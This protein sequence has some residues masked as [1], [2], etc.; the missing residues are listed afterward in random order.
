MFF[1]MNRFIFSHPT[2]RSTQSTHVS[3]PSSTRPHLNP[4]LFSSTS[5]EEPLTM[6]SMISTTTGY[7]P[8]SSQSLDHQAQRIPWSSSH[9]DGSNER[10][11][12]IAGS[13][14]THWNPP[15]SRSSS[16]HNQDPQADSNPLHSTTTEINHEDELNSKIDKRLAE[17]STLA[18]NDHVTGNEGS[19]ACTN[20]NGNGES[21]DRNSDQWKQNRKNNHKEV[22]RR[23]RET[24]NE[25]ITEL[26]KIIP[27]TEKNKGE[28]LKQAVKYIQELKETEERNQDRWRLEKIRLEE[29]IQ[30]QSNKFETL[31]RDYLN[32]EAE[33]ESLKRWIIELGEKKTQ[34]MP[35]RRV[36]EEQEEEEEE[37]HDHQRVPSRTS[38]EPTR[39]DPQRN[40]TSNK[41]IPAIYIHNPQHQETESNIHHLLRT[42]TEEF[43]MKRSTDND[44]NDQPNSSKKFKL[45]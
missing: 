29:S 13:S 26:K 34:S 20:G 19:D 16:P 32:L 1:W 30:E 43:G 24:I 8:S 21:V 22:E 42:E 6:N 45:N 27:G 2:L 35:F 41:T 11:E 37:D 18:W 31:S 36:R 3:S 44:D 38:S 17:A 39:I 15:R 33:N 5:Q 25:G 10:E 14:H 40:S 12:P 4:N 7:H 9:E 28:I 23:R